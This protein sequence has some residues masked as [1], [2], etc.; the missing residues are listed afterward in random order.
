MPM[1]LGQLQ[2]TFP[3]QAD[4]EISLKNMLQ[5]LFKSCEHFHNN[6]HGLIKPS[7]SYSPFP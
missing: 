3:K 4:K 2:A 5:N 1:M 6:F 7:G